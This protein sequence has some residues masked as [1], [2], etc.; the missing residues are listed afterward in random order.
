MAATKWGLATALALRVSTLGATD[1][2]QSYLDRVLPTARSTAPPPRKPMSREERESL[3]ALLREDLY[4]WHAEVFNPLAFTN[5]TCVRM[6]KAFLNRFAGKAPLR[7]D[8]VKMQRN[9]LTVRQGMLERAGAF[10]PRTDNIRELNRLLCETLRLHVTWMTRVTDQ[11]FDIGV[12]PAPADLVEA[13]R[14][15]TR[16]FAPYQKALSG[17][18][19]SDG[20]RGDSEGEQ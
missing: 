6:R 3:D 9:V 11:Q 2:K 17:R 4:S 14:A 7:E 13:K 18:S 1:Y 5:R 12:C 8:I 15:F 19:D 20:G 10:V 16:A